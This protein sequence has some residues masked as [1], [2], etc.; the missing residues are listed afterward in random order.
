MNILQKAAEIL[1]ECGYAQ[2]TWV[3]INGCVAIEKPVSGHA[4]QCEP[5]S[6][7]LEGWKQLNAIK[8]W[9]MDTPDHWDL[10]NDT[11]DSIERNK[12][13]HDHDLA[14]IECCLEELVKQ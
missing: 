7:T 8:T 2:H 9:F 10:W 12:S 4:Y 3:N 5:F 11:A 6:D 13:A 14:I 1:V